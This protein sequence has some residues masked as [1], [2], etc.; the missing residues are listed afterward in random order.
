[1]VPWCNRLRPAQFAEIFERH[2]FEVLEVHPYTTIP[3]T[4]QSR[5]KFAEPF[6]SMPLETLAVT[7]ARFCVRKR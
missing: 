7:Q 2:G 6:R 1:M 4:E 3:M 5:Q